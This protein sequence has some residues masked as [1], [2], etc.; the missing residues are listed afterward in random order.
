MLVS[1]LAYSSR[2]NM[3]GKCTSETTVNFH[4]SIGCVIR[5]DTLFMTTVAWNSDATF[6]NYLAVKCSVFTLITSR[7]EGDVGFAK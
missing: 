5:G 3:R 2:L 6:S 4:W 1:Y 7:I